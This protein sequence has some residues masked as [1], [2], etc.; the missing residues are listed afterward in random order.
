[1]HRFKKQIREKC[2]GTVKTVLRLR[3]TSGMSGAAGMQLFN[4]HLVAVNH[5]GW[6]GDE[7]E[8]TL[9]DNLP[10]HLMDI[11]IAVRCISNTHN[12]NVPLR[13]CFGEP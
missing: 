3:G 6:P 10:L 5:L 8:A 7:L 12:Q 1:L 4:V 11:F 13:L 2:V 9:A